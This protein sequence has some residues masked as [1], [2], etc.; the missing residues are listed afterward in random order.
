MIESPL[1]KE[2]E[3]KARHEDILLLLTKRFGAVPAEVSSRLRK[4]LRKKRL[5]ELLE[6]TLDCPNVEAFRDKLLS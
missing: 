6:Y 3:A 2:I 5:D 1:I 4:I